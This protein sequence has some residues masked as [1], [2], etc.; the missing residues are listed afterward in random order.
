MTLFES[1]ITLEASEHFVNSAAL[2]DV[3]R[4]ES[5]LSWAGTQQAK[6]GFPSGAARSFRWTRNCCV[7]SVAGVSFRDVGTPLT[8]N[9]SLERSCN[10]RGRAV[11]AMNCVLGGAEVAPCLDAQLDR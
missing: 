10:H 3:A 1:R 4:V 2:S 11:L 9:I 6:R 8:S 7:W 5:C